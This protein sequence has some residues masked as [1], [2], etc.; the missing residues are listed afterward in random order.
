MILITKNLLSTNLKIP[1]ICKYASQGN[2]KKIKTL[3]KAGKNVDD[4]DH[5]MKTPLIH[6]CQK[7][8]I[9]IVKYLVENK[10]NTNWK[11]DFNHRTPLSIAAENGH[12]DIVKYLVK[13]GADVNLNPDYDTL[14]EL[15][16]DE[17]VDPS[18]GN[19]AIFLAAKKGHFEIAQYLHSAGANITKGM[20][21]NAK[22]LE[23]DRAEM[24]L[25]K[26]RALKRRPIHKDRFF[27]K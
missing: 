26:V 4:Y 17:I 13:K 7:G 15:D 6:A 24:I 16:E 27:N 9:N 10:A 12:L 20:V 8:H 11:Q 3:I 25:V 18:V 21:E 14:E 22:N 2:L 1:E 19:T 5:E 23:H